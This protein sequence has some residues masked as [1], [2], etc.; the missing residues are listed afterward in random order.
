MSI[1]I[2]SGFLAAVQSVRAYLATNNVDAVVEVGWRKR[3]R[4]D[5]QAP[6]GA[7]RVVFT[8]SGND[9]GDGG[10]VG[11]VRFA[12]HR[13]IRDGSDAVVAD[14]RSLANWERK[15]LVSVWA[16]DNSS[17]AKLRDEEAQIEAVETLFEW[18]LRAVQAAPGAFAEVSWGGVSFTPPAERSFGLELRASLTFSHPIFDKPRELVSAAPGAITRAAYT[19]PTVPSSDGDT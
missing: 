10:T 15:A 1:I 17:P 6:T 7:N 9:A 11:P 2:R 8:P 3:Q 13:N 18:V 4:Q 19:P 16:V 14:V 12:G 5:N